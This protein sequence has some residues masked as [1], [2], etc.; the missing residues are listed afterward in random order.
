MGG[1]HGEDCGV[2]R[3]NE[4]RYNAQTLFCF[5]S[6]SKRLCWHNCRIVREPHNMMANGTMI[7]WHN[8]SIASWFHGT[9][10][11]WTNGQ[12]DRLLCDLTD[13]G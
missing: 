1:Q 9:V 10:D 12:M 7:A 6:H 13:G 2:G 5:R 3:T 11:E 8:S 4:T